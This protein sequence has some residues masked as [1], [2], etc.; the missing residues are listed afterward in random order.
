MSLRST[1]EI[2]SD[3][4]ERAGT[5]YI[6]GYPGGQN[7]RFI[8][9]LYGSKVKFILVT[10]EACAGFMADVYSRLTGNVG[11]CLSTLGPGATNMT[12]GVGNAFLD[13][14]PVLAFTAK[15]GR[16]WKGR[17]VQMQIDHRKLYAPITKWSAE[18]ET[19]RIYPV[20]TKA[21]TVALSEQPGPVHLDFPEDVAEELSPE[22]CFGFPSAPPAVGR[23]DDQALR[24]AEKLIAQAKRPLVA[25]GLTMNRARATPELREFIQKHNLPVVSTMMAKGHIDEDSSQFVGVLGRAKRDIV[26]EYCHPADLVIAIGYD[27]IEFSYEDWLPKDVPLIHIDSVPADIAPGFSVACEI[28]GDIRT[29]LQRLLQIPLINHQWED[30]HREAH[31]KKLKEAFK[32]VSKTFTPQQ[33]LS[34]MRE[35]LPADGILVSDVGAHTHIIGQLWNPKEPGRLLVSNGWSSMGFAIPAAIA[36]KLVHPERPVMACTGDGGFLMM[37]GEIST[38]VRLSLPVIFIVLRDNYLSL[39]NVKQHR[40]KYHPSGVALFNTDY[41]SSDNFFGAEVI[42]AAEEEE[43]R[44]ALHRA[45]KCEK[46]IVIETL[47]DPLEYQRL[48]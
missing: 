47:I 38:A 41:R 11:A 12:T 37:V 20:L 13:R 16:I 1:A 29:S 7:I 21:I 30:Y 10:H 35:V 43:F 27:P 9:A 44:A 6:F 42:V 17:T 28:C 2:V 48:I 33:A 46:P 25:I 5:Q 39:I 22:T 24:D 23:P 26:G 4:L 3:C 8:E 45:L 31:R 15:M 36:A 32:P 18:L 34:A 40:K 14:V 19:G